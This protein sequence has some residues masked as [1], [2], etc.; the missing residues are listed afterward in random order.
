LE[1][2][3]APAGDENFGAAETEELFEEAEPDPGA[4]AGYEGNGCGDVEWICFERGHDG[5]RCEAL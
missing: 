4:S 5:K 1:D 3:F 2:V